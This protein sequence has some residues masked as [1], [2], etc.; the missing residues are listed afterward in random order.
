MMKK[1]RNKT[2]SQKLDIYHRYNKKIGVYSFLKSNYK[3]ILLVFAVFLAIIVVVNYF[4]DLE[5]AAEFI[6]NNYT[7]DIIFLVFYLSESILGL[8]PPDIFILWVK[9][10]EDPYLMLGILGV[11]SYLGGLTAYG[12]GHRLERVPKIREYLEEKY[13]VHINK[14]K[15][16]GG[17]F[18]IIAA[19]LPLPYA[20]VLLLAGMLKYPF[21]RVLYLGIARIARFFIHGVVLFGVIS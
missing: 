21:S 15:K 20:T 13:S 9:G 6:V 12:I 19:L 3:K 4:Y 2:W 14:I 10:F 18:I 7:T 16:W 5:T 17:I 8:I 1:R 11:I